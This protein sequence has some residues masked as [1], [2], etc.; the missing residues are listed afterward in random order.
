MLGKKGHPARRDSSPRHQT[1]NIDS[2][3]DSTPIIA[4]A[5][6]LT[7]R[8]D[9]ARGIP[10]PMDLFADAG[11][12]ALADAGCAADQLDTIAAIRLFSDTV[13]TWASPFG[14]SNNPPESVARRLGA[15]IE[16]RIYS[17]ASGTEPVKVMAELLRRVADGEIGTA[18]L[19]GGEGIAG[20]R[21]AQRQGIELQWQEE[22]SADLDDRVY[23]KR[24][25]CQ[26]EM[27]S[28]MRMPAH[29]YALMENHQAAT[30]GHDY[31]QHRQFMGALFEPFSQVAAQ[32]PMAWSQQSFT[33]EEIAE[34]SDKNFPICLPYT[35]RLVASDGV[36]QAAALVITS[37]GRARAMGIAPELWVVLGQYAVGEENPLL[38]RPSP[39]RSEVMAEVFR[40]CL[41]ADG[42][43][44]SAFPV[45]DVYSCFPIAVSAALEAL[46]LPSDGSVTPTITGGLPYFGG[47]GNA[48]CLQVL[49]E[50]VA[51]VRGS[52]QH[53]LITANGG[54]LSSHA[55]GI[56]VS[57]QEAS[58]AALREGYLALPVPPPEDFETREICEHPD[59]GIVITHTVIHDRKHPDFA[60]VMAE[61]FAGRR[62]LAR[63]E[64]PAT[65]ASILAQSPVGRSIAVSA[66]ERG[67]QFTFT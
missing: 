43:P 61:D 53:A 35:R 65:V 39:S 48:Y 23:L 66:A 46:N 36:N 64:E 45:L 32:H 26:A 20:Q 38:L 13:K 50:M 47:P 17:N 42:R 41:S 3:P 15:N 31:A 16:R 52:N 63:S 6:Q 51:R 14:G 21:L 11:R 18:L 4:G 59:R 67:H 9:P 44:A 33:A 37:A 40:Q 58:E 54:N 60:V 29:Y 1:L 8:P 2:I 22:L 12:R 19:V 5:A 56:L 28:G 30:K 10:A 25:V 57:A 34:P 49:A 55:A 24:V 62:F 7:A 27:D